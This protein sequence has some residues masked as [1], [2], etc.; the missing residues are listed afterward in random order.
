MKRRYETLLDRQHIMDTAIALFK[1]KGYD[2]VTVNEICKEANIAY[3]TFFYQF[4]NKGHLLWEYCINQVPYCYDLRAAIAEE[5]PLDKLMCM[6]RSYVRAQE[7]LGAPLL[8]QF[9]I[10]RMQNLDFWRQYNERLDVD[11]DLHCDLLRAAQERGEV[12]TPLDPHV[13]CKIGIDLSFSLFANWAIDPQRGEL[14][15]YF[16]RHVEILYDV[17]P[18]KRRY[19]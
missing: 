18:H 17:A 3:S 10:L 2:H 6:L 7:A 12:L 15:P 8:M 14:E 4:K 5:S 16:M 11:L 19:S 9:L 13:I 1:E